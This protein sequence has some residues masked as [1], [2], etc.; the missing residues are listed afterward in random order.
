MDQAQLEGFM[1][2]LT[3]GE[4]E[5]P[6]AGTAEDLAKSLSSLPASEMSKL[7]GM[8][9]SG[10][11]LGSAVTT[12]MQAPT[13]TAAGSGAQAGQYGFDPLSFG[14]AFQ[15]TIG[16]WMAQQGKTFNAENSQYATNMANALKGASPQLQAAFK[17]SVPA[18][19]QAMAGEN[20]AL[21]GA[22]ITS[23]EFDSLISGLNAATTA[24]KATTYGLADLPFAEAAEGVPSS[25]YQ[26]MLQSALSGQTPTGISSLTPT[27]ISPATTAA[28]QGSS[29]TN[30][31]LQQNLQ[32]NAP[33]A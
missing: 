13:S 33:T 12:D 16:P 15:N 9:P 2:E 22:A 20:Q 3:G 4:E 24:A 18:M 17:T 6:S 26:A 31:L 19:Q 29:L 25:T 21:E 30:A 14:L 32:Q 5:Q 28:Q 1:K 8:L 23:P 7:M 11:A 10:S 27:A